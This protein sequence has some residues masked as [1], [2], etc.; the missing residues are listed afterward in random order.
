MTELPAWLWGLVGGLV[1][2]PVSL[3]ILWPACSRGALALL[4]RLVISMLLK[5]AL[6]GIG[7]YVAIKH[8]G[9]P[10]RELIIGFFAGYLISLA[11]EITLCIWKVRRCASESGSL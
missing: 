11:V 7:L 5:L 2:G 6:A 4:K 9:L 8:L 3:A 1:L 10:A